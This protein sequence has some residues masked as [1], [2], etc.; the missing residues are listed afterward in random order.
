MNEPT[1]NSLICA[2]HFD[3]KFILNGKRKKLNWK[4]NPVPNIYP[5]S[6]LS[7]PSF[8]TTLTGFRKSPKPRIYQPDQLD[9]FVE[10]DKIQTLKI[11]QR[12]IVFM[13]TPGI[14]QK[15]LYCFM[16]CY[17]MIAVA[18]PLFVKP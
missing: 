17:L 15:T 9:N 3:Q 1:S 11:Y 5:E 14:K 6:L 13:V 7:K 12:N 16:F 18:F 10:K 8:L 4:L 2:N